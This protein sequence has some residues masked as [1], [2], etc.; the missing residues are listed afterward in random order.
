MCHRFWQLHQATGH[1]AHVVLAPPVRTLP[2]CL[3]LTLSSEIRLLSL[4]RVLPGRE[5]TG[6][7]RDM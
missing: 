4:S 5:R 6:G 2:C 3:G 1:M 7:A